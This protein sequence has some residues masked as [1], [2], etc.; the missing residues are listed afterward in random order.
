MPHD[1]LEAHPFILMSQLLELCA[2]FRCLNYCRKFRSCLTLDAMKMPLLSQQQ[3][4]NLLYTVPYFI[5]IDEEPAG[6]GLIETVRCVVAAL[7]TAVVKTSA[8]VFD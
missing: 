6:G 4:L 3:Q 8:L 7:L 5:V 1:K 2:K